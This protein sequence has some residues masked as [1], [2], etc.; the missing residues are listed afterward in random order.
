MEE[1]L[2]MLL[3][4]KDINKLFKFYWK[5]ENQMLILQ[6]RC[7]FV[8]FVFFFFFFVFFHFLI[9]LFFFFLNQKNGM[10]PLYVAAAQGHDQIVE[11]LLEKGKPN[12]DLANKV[13]FCLIISFS[14]FFFSLSLIF[15]IFFECK[16]RNNS[17]FYCCSKWAWTNCSN[18]IGKKK[19]KCWFCRSGY[20]LLILCS[21]FLFLFLF[22]LSLIFL[23]F[24]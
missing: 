2:F 12:V 21:F 4:L 15:L 8:W 20:F 3:L 22:S 9:F 6:I 10:T 23:F 16:E 5:K 24:F 14:V 19:T 17:S 1:L 13:L 18:F 7:Y 11:L